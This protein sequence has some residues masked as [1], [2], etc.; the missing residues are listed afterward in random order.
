MQQLA[1]EWTICHIESPKPVRVY[2]FLFFYCLISNQQEAKATQLKEMTKEKNLSLGTWR[3]QG[4][5]GK[6]GREQRCPWCRRGVW[7]AFEWS[8]WYEKRHCGEIEPFLLLLVLLWNEIEV[9]S[10]ALD[11]RGK[12]SRVVSR[13]EPWTI[14]LSLTISQSL[15]C[16][17]E[18]PFL[19][20]V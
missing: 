4:R 11:L 14:C 16:L 2:Q 17:F 1:N 5:H 10:R 19:F 7:E 6:K 18:N 12:G 8:Y 20:F 13:A 9:S 3:R 15:T